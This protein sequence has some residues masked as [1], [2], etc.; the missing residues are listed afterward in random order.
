MA[1][2]HNARDGSPRRS[3]K[4]LLGRDLTAG[5]TG[6]MHWGQEYRDTHVAIYAECLRVLKPGAPF[7]LNISDHIRGGVIVP[8]SQWHTDTLVDLGFDFVSNTNVDTPRMR[9]GANRKRVQHEHVRVFSK[10]LR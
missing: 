10:P 5:N 7:I 2:H 1:D 3:Y 4:H 6:Q 8:V 9:F